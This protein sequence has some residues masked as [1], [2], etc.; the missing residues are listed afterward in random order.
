MWQSNRGCYRGYLLGAVQLHRVVRG[1]AVMGI[2]VATGSTTTR[3]LI[4][5][6]H[7]W[8]FE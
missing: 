8:P 1:G 6:S 5:A 3:S 4:T 7:G 2:H